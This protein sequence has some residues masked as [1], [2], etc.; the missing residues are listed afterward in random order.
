MSN[1]KLFFSPSYQCW[2][3]NICTKPEFIAEK[4][5]WIFETC[6]ETDDLSGVAAKK[7]RDQIQQLAHGLWWIS[8]THSRGFGT[9]EAGSH[10]GKATGGHTMTKWKK[11]RWQMRIMIFHCQLVQLC[12]SRF[13]TE[14]SPWQVGWLLLCFPE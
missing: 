10:W 13:L 7:V 1:F 9:T 2:I 4:C 8:I 6:L 14:S 11:G 5:T 12:F 3:I